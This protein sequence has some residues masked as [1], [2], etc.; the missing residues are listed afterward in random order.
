[1]ID[2]T[3]ALLDHPLGGETP[4]GSAAAAGLPEQ[5]VPILGRVPG[6]RRRRVDRLHGLPG[7]DGIGQDAETLAVPAVRFGHDCR[8]RT[9]GTPGKTAADQPAAGT[10]RAGRFSRNDGD[11]LLPLLAGEEAGGEVQQGVEGQGGGAGAQQ[12]LRL[13]E[14]GRCARGQGGE[15]AGERGL[16]AVVR[17]DE[18]GQA[19]RR[20]RSPR[21]RPRR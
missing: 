10:Q 17:D 9:G 11:A 16:D 21:R 14:R 8:I 13:G 2:R 3:Q 18:I 12:A 6:R 1:M 20:R 5:P 15:Q 19:R 7:Q 4:Q